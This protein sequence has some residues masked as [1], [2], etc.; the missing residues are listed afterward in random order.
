MI[1]EFLPRI[2]KTTD[3]VAEI[4]YAMREQSVGA[5]HIKQA[6]G[7]LDNGIQKSSEMARVTSENAKALSEQS[8]T[9][10]E[11]IGYFRSSQ[12]GALKPSLVTTDAVQSATQQSIL[13]QVA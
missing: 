10:D 5:E 8:A 1:E 11:A 4:S 13:K 2:V 6:I 12:P 9:L 7:E 3:L